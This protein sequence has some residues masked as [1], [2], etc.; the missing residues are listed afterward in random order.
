MATSHYDN[1]Y[2]AYMNGDV[3]TPP[4]ATEPMNEYMEGWSEAQL[5]AESEFENQ[6]EAELELRSEQYLAN[7]VD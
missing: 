5:D 2:N 4:S 6:M 3:C 1:G 7:E